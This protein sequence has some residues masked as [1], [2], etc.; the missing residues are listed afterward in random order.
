M[1]FTFEARCAVHLEYFGGEKKSSVRGTDF[2][3]DVSSN[4]DRRVYLDE[5]DLPTPEGSKA[6][7]TVLVT[8]LIAN[9]KLAQERGWRNESDHL[10]YVINCLQQGF[11]TNVDEIQKGTFK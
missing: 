10:R 11:I 7:T 8:G 6:I 2:N 9:I 4:L 5:E 3:L 1:L